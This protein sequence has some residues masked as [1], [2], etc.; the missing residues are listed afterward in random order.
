M[1]FGKTSSLMLKYQKAK[2]KLIEYEVPIKDYPDFPLDSRELSYPTTYILSR[3]SEC[4][5]ENNLEELKELKPFLNSVAQYYD[6][7]FSSKEDLGYSLDFL[8]SGASAYFLNNDFGS[9]KVL[10]GKIKTELSTR[11]PQILLINIYNYCKRR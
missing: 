5:I 11:N 3:Y 8:L 7:A 1:I 2:S 10:S 9:A 4:I 6:S